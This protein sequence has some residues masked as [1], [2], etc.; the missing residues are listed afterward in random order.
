MPAS[1][2]Q[3]K[4]LVLLVFAAVVGLLLVLLPFL[5][6]LFQGYLAAQYGLIVTPEGKAVAGD[7]NMPGMMTET[8]ISL[9]IN[10]F[11]VAKVLLWMALVISL[12]RFVGNIV[13]AT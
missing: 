11:H 10:L 5:E 13:F 6:T 12:V 2:F 9:V 4:A 7:G 1:E 8:T 3:K